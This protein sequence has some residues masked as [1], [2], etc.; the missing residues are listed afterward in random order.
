MFID[1]HSHFLHNIDDGAVDIDMAAEMLKCSKVCGTEFVVCTPHCNVR[2]DMDILCEKR[3]SLIS[4]IK[5]FCCK[6]ELDIPQIVPGF[7]VDFYCL[8]NSSEKELKKLCIGN[9]PYILIE[10]PYSG[11]NS[12]IFEVLY[13][14][15]L[16]NIKPVV[17]HIDRYYH[18]IGDAVFDIFD[19]DVD[20]Q[21]NCSA[22]TNIPGRNFVKKM[23]KAG[24]RCTVGTDMHNLTSRPCNIKAAYDIA[25]KKFKDE[26]D[27]IF[28]TNAYNMISENK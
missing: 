12:R 24:K 19:Y 27:R 14:L 9:S 26:C 2:E 11:W 13:N 17:A 25:V 20:F 23:L 28:Y 5:D 8:G 7:E 15:T 3:D 10:M 18:M 21:I 1:F 16:K 6:Y 4:E 22:F